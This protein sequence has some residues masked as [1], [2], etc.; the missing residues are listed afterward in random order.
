[1]EGD[2]KYCLCCGE[3]V[4]YNTVV[5]NERRELT[6][7]YCGFTLD[8]ENLWEE[9]KPVSQTYALIAEDSPFMRKLLKELLLK[10]SLATEVIDAPN[11][12]EFVSAYSK[13]LKKNIIPAFVILDL[14][15]PVMDGLT[16]ARTMRT[17]EESSGARKTPI[18][19]FSS[20]KADEALKKQMTL[21]APANY[22]N[23]GASA[24]PEKLARRVEGLLHFIMNRQE[25]LSRI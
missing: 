15:M 2:T 25:R 16:A 4:P 20:L 19:F 3:D 22:V 7:T 10:K 11:G 12:L 8:V 9:H 17:L 6:C 5:R 13:L 18:I 23:K 24:E 14:N 1:M 21:L